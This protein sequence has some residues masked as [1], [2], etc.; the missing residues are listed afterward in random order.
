MKKSLLPFVV[1]FGV[2]VTLRAQTPVLADDV[3]LTPS[4]FI[5]IFSGLVLALVFQF[6]LTAVSIAAGVTAIGDVKK[7]FV[8]AQARPGGSDKDRDQTFEQDYSSDTPMG[9]KLSTAFGIWSV[10]T[11]CIALFGATALALNLS[12]IESSNINAAIALVIWG[13]FF[14]ILFYLEAKVA[15]TLIGNLISTAT[16]GLK[17]SAGAIS[18]MFSS[19]PETKME[20][21][22][23]PYPPKGPF[24]I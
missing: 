22:S 8:K 9:V 14:L 4:F 19:S 21:R 17:A 23:G 1:L 13:L 3:I 12:T 20:K 24:G 11:T 5:T 18:S 7:K 15:R 6:L 16:S 2:S 10:I